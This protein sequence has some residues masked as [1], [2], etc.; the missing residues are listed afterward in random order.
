MALLTLLALL[1]GPIL[2]L[3]LL[4]DLAAVHLGEGG[5]KAEV[6]ANLLGFA[7]GKLLWIREEG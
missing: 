1:V 4:V 5:P 7:S 3:F 6:K 2:V